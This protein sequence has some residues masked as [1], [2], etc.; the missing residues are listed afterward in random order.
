MK[1]CIDCAY[2]RKREG[3]IFGG[4]FIKTKYLCKSDVVT[5]RSPVTGEL[6]EIDCEEERRNGVS[7]GPFARL[8][9]PKKQ[10]N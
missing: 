2:C 6:K 1:L 8:F 10:E 5:E 4:I 7:C 9:C 3:G